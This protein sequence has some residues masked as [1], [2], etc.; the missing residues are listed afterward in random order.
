MPIFALKSLSRACV[1]EDAPGDYRTARRVGQY[2]LSGQAVYFPAFP[3]TRYLPFGAL[4]QVWTEKTSV[5]LT[6]CC[7]KELPMVRL[8][9]RYDGEYY[10]NFMFE[11]QEEADRVLDCIR[12]RRPEISFQRE[13]PASAVTR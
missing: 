1:L 2:Q 7:G 12:T 6:G 4:D 13:T 9:A 11:K 10:Q 8:R 3:G 5:P